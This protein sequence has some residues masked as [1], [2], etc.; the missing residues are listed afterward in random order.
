M[1]FQRRTVSQI[2]RE[3]SDR[4]RWREKSLTIQ[5]L[6]Q[7]R[8]EYGSVNGQGNASQLTADGSGKQS[9]SR[10]FASD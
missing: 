4:R 5:S 7:I 1:A 6:S 2:N 3:A 10:V 8:R 9:S